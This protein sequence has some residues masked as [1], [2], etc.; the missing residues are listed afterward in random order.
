[1][2][3]MVVHVLIISLVL[4][5]IIRNR[6]NEKKLPTFVAYI[7]LEKAFDRIDRT[8]LYYKLRSRGFGGKMYDHRFY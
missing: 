7:D 4:T 1:M 2:N 3:K 5:S 8:F 6:K